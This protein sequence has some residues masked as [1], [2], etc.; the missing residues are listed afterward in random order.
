MFGRQTRDATH[1]RTVDLP[2]DVTDPTPPPLDVIETIPDQTIE[3]TI[4]LH[5]ELL[6]M[7]R[8]HSILTRHDDAARVRILSWVTDQLQIRPPVE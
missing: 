4:D 8:I 2:G 1:L 3:E 5:Q 6:A 7:A